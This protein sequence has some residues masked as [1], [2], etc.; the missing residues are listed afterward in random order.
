MLFVGFAALALA[1][2]AVGAY[3]VML[4]S[5]SQKTRE[6]G[7]R[8]ALGARKRDIARLV[9]GE[10]LVPAVT[11]IGI[12]LAG[13]VAAARLMRTLLFGVAPTDAASFAAAVVVLGA[14]AALA[15]WIPARRAARIDPVVA[16]RDR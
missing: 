12:G 16:L 8:L 2:A 10:G 4:Y 14:M 15:C 5:V 9:A 13:A 11:G 6:I 1:L 3:A 7:V